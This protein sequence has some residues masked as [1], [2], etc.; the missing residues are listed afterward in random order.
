LGQVPSQSL[1][2]I[3]EYASNVQYGEVESVEKG[4]RNTQGEEFKNFEELTRKLVAVPKE[5]LDKRRDIYQENK[6]KSTKPD[7]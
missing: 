6:D 2:T 7:E 5:D 4:T 3:L 1:E